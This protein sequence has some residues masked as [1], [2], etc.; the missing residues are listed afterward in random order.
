MGP[1]VSMKCGSSVIIA[2]VNVCSVI[3]ANPPMM[4]IISLLSPTDEL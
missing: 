3:I 2:K 1:S 4:M